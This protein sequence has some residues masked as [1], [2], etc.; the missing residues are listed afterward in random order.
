[1][2]DKAESLYAPPGSLSVA[3]R[4]QAVARETD[5]RGKDDEEVSCGAFGYLRGL[6][7]R[8]LTLELR[9]KTGDREA[10]PYGLLASVRFNPSAGILLKLTSDVVTLI[11]IKGSNLDLPVHLGAVDLIERGLERHRVTYIREMDE[12]ELRKAGE[13]EPTIDRIEV[14]EC[15]SQEEIREWLGKTAAAF[16]R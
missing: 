6:H 5:P 14:A 13:R 4:L 15:E 8:S 1:M 10:Y 11:F 12:H 2:N 16:L 3:Q 7:E 9:F